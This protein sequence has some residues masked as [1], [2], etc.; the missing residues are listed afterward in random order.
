[1]TRQVACALN[2]KQLRFQQSSCLRA[3][4]LE[5]RFCTRLKLIG[6]A[7]AVVI[8]DPLARRVFSTGFRSVDA[9]FSSLIRHARFLLIQPIRLPTREYQMLRRRQ[10]ASRL[11]GQAQSGLVITRLQSPRSQYQHDNLRTLP[12]SAQVSRLGS[13]LHLGS[14]RPAR[15]GPNAAH[16]R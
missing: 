15:P 8:T 6:L 7:C 11:L 12:M 5:N 4:K 13:V 14:E 1:M 10:P 16:L 9:S 3:Y 2:R